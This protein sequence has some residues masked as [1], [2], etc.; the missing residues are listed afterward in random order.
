MKQFQYRIVDEDHPR[1]SEI[2][3]LVSEG[4]IPGS[5][6]PLKMYTFEFADAE[7]E[8]LMAYQF[9]SVLEGK[10]EEDV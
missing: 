7:K 5:N 10:G 9:V 2:G 4:V 1:F 3:L 6:P 8:Y